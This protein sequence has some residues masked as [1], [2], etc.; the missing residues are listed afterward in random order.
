MAR[1]ACAQ[2]RWWRQLPTPAVPLWPSSLLL[3]SPRSSWCPTPRSQPSPPPGLPRPQVLRCLVGHFK[4]LAGPCQD[5]V[6]RGVRLALWGFRLGAPLT[7]ACDSDVQV[8]AVGQ[9]GAAC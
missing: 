5:E 7:Q 3:P 2:L 8:G 1:W 4:Q 9:Q 6:S